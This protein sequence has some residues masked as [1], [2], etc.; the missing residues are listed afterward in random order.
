MSREERRQY[1]R[2]MKGVDRSPVPPI[3]PAARARLERNKARRDARR[4]APAG[5]LTTRFWLMTL[6]IA[7]VIGLGAFSLAWPSGMP[8]ALYVGIGAA[9]LAAAAQVALRFLQRRLPGA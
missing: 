4:S 7:F 9:V 1:Q 3:D 8:F 6:A 2:M 5:A